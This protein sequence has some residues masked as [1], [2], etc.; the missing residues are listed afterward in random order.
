MAKILLKDLMLQV[1]T[2]QLEKKLVNMVFN[3]KKNKKLDICMV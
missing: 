1:C 2:E 3:Y